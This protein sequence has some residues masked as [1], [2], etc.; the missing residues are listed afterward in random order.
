MV[1]I[2]TEA[3]RNGGLKESVVK[4][5]NFV[6]LNTPPVGH[7]SERGEYR[8]MPFHPIYRKVFESRDVR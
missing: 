5:L 3:K 8:V 6:V 2:S 7:P 1:V 4:S